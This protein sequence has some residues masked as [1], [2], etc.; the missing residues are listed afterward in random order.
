MSI[1]L[2][3][4]K[5]G[6][7]LIAE[8]KELVN[9]EKEVKGYLL[10]KPHKVLTNTPLLL[11]E[12]QSNDSSVE[13][14]LSPWILLSEDQEVVVQPDWVITV[15]QPLPSVIKMYKEKLKNGQSN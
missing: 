4:L 2:V 13:V 6:E 15:V 12:E 8:A 14:T 11:T 9:D 10:D 1:K 7:Q 3:M 5:S